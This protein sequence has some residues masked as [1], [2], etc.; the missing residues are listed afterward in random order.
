MHISIVDSVYK[1]GG[2]SDM[3]VLMIETASDI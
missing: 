3:L 1:D 2:Y